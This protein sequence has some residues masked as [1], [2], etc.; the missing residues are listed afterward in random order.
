MFDFDLQT[1]AFTA[2]VWALPVL[3][4]ITLHEAAHA[5]VAWKLGDDTAQQQGRVTFNPL[6]HIDLF[7]TIIMPALLLLGSGGRMMFGYAKPVPVNFARLRTPRRDMVLVAAAGPASNVLLAVLSALALYLVPFL[8][9]DF[10]EWTTRNLLNSVWINLLL[11]LFNMLPIPPLD[12]GRV[13]V[14]VLPYRLAAPLARLEQSGMLIILGLVFLLPFLGRSIGVDLNVFSW[15]VA[16]PAAVMMR[17]L[18]SVL[19]IT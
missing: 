6:S 8:S 4:A 5:W 16:E 13:A 17:G 18:L 2:S 14:G 12:G 11:C 1:I 7:G 9:G 3:V 15:V 19:G 10:A